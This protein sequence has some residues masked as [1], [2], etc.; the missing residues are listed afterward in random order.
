MSHHVTT[1]DID[2]KLTLVAEGTRAHAALVREGKVAGIIGV[3]K[4]DLHMY[5]GQ[6]RLIAAAQHACERLIAAKVS[7]EIYPRSLR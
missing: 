4:A 7:K 5:I 2:T 3:A 1:A 6:A